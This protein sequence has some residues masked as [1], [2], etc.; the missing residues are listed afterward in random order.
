[1]IFEGIRGYSYTSD[2]AIDNVVLEE[3]GGGGAGG[4]GGCGKL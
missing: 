3:C 4:G 2:I 1:L